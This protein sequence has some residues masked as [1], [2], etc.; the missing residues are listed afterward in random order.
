MENGFVSCIANG[1]A[2]E[3]GLVFIVHVHKICAV[4]SIKPARSFCSGTLMKASIQI[5]TIINV[6][7]ESLSK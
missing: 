6:F 7:Y 4:L 3:S 2:G 5:Q 1:K